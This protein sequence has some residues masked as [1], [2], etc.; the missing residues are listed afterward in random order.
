MSA[1]VL[2]FPAQT[3]CDV[4]GRACSEDDLGGCFT[5]DTRFCRNC[6]ECECDKET[7]E[8]ADRLAE[9]RPGLLTRLILHARRVVNAVRV[10]LAA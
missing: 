1:T 6:H 4:C 7:A 2:A 9:L 5:C 10:K 3:A 8:L